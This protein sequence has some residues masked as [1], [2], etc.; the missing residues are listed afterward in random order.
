MYYLIHAVQKDTVWAAD[1]TFRTKIMMVSA[2][3]QILRDRIGEIY[4]TQIENGEVYDEDCDYD[5]EFNY[6]SF[7]SFEDDGPTTNY[8]SICSDI[9]IEENIKRN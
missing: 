5:W 2:E 3:K 8:Y 4:R 6:L 1:P 9:A 7:F